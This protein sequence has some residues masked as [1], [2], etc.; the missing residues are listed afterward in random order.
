[1]EIFPHICLW[2]NVVLVDIVVHVDMRK[3]VLQLLIVM[4][5]NWREGIEKIGINLF[6]L[7]HDIP[8]R[9]LLVGGSLVHVGLD[10]EEI[11]SKSGGVESEV[12]TVT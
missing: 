4:I 9:L 10:T 11:D 2:V 7:G 3:D 6:G 1:M 5:G 8:F 12:G